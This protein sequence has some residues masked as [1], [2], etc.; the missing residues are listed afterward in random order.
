MPQALN[1]WVLRASQ[2]LLPAW[3]RLQLAIDVGSVQAENVETLVK[4]YQQFEAGQSRIMLAF[5][6][7]N[8]MDPFAMAYLL[9]YLVPRTARSMG[10]SL[11]SLTHSYFLYDRGIPLWAGNFVSWLFPRLGGSSLFRGKADRIG[12]KAARELFANGPIPISLAPEGG[13]NEHSERMSPLE[14]GAAQLGFWCMEDLLKAERTETVLIVP[15]GLHY[16]YLS[17]PWTP[18]EQL[19]SQLEQGAGLS[20]A[21]VAGPGLLASADTDRLY[22]RLLRLG[23]HLLDQMEAWYARY[24]PQAW[25]QVHHAS[26]PSTSASEPT[27]VPQALAA[28]LQT[29]AQV[30]V[31]VSEAGLGLKPKGSPLAR[32]RRVEQAAWD[33]IYRDDVDHLSPL[34][35]GLADWVAA[36]ASLSLQHMRIVERLA[37]LTGDYIL[38]KPTADRFADVLLILWKLMTWIQGGDPSQAPKLGKRTMG[39]TVGSPI[40]VSER[41]PTYAANRRSARQAVTDL[42]QELQSALEQ[43]LP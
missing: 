12:L 40:S 20:D 11:R 26:E 16:H 36:E 5:R 30:I 38:S 1:P 28:R 29:L 27:E 19:L 35:R 21:Q 7:P 9:W 23:T 17:P 41:W 42:T 10:I 22:G 3:L 4:L 37:V 14:P 24:Y 34:E 31:Q 43:M 25:S 2:Y 13:T 18:L 39:I 33:R 15:I 32:C 8:T 6:H